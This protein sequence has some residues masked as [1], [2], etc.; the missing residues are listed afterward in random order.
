M[1][2]LIDARFYGLENAGLGRYTTNLVE[3][4]K[5]QGKK[6]EYVVLLRSKYFK[7]LKFPENWKKVEAEVEHYSFEEQLKLP[8]I[9]KAQ[10]PDLVHFPH[11]NVPVFYF[12]KYVVTIHDMLMHKFRGTDTTTL[13]PLIYL[14]K[15]FL[16]YDLVFASA[17][18]RAQKVIVP[19][20]AIQNEV[21]KFY[22]KE[23]RD[24]VVTYEGVGNNF[25]KGTSKDKVLK[26]YKI[27]GDYFV[28]TGNAYP[29]KNL[30]RLIDALVQ[31]NEEGKSAK[32]FIASSRDAFVERL[33]KL[34][35]EKGAQDYVKLLGFVPDEELATLYKNSVAF[36]YP[37]LSEGFG[38]QGLE[39]MTAGTLV[40]VSD[41]PVFKE[42]YKD[43]SV[44]F[45][46]ESVESMVETKKKALTL[47]A[48]SRKEIIKSS[49]KFARK[50]SWSDMAKETLKVYE[51]TV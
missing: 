48:K 34:I 32:L 37:S 31:L 25:T 30:D 50:Y 16:G 42:V 12:G 5:K 33:E 23:K 47:T 29:H 21:S 40:L 18:K 49:T 14:V 43:S 8:G 10:K 19:T 17:V 2:I 35:K 41:I 15:R 45:D 44:Y 46:P 1:R 13:G 28:Y 20:K 6:N 7:N 36:V 38:L 4:L 3:E 27:I 39:A 11:F 24:A 51:Q 26:K 22:N 9:I